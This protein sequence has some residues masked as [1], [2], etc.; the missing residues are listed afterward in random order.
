MGEVPPL[1]EVALDDAVRLLQLVRERVTATIVLQRHV[2]V[3]GRLGARVFAR[4]SPHSTGPLAWFVE[5]DEGLDPADPT[6]REPVDAALAAAR[7][8]VGE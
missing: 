7:G 3:R 8:D 2:T 5:Y 1:H 6:V 4:R